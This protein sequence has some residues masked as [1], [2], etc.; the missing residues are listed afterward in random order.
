MRSS[1]FVP[2]FSI[3]H[4]PVSRSSFLVSRPSFSVTRLPVSRSSFSV[5]YH[6]VMVTVDSYVFLAYSSFVRWLLFVSSLPF[7]PRRLDGHLLLMS[8]MV[9]L[10]LNSCR[11]HGVPF[12]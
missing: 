12:L 8:R 5:R 1:I 3:P 7:V 11:I 6:G 9:H 10:G 4:L 2:R